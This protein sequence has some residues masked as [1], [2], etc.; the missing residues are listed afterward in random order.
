MRPNSEPTLQFPAWYARETP[1]LW[2]W[3]KGRALYWEESINFMDWNVW[4]PLDESEPE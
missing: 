1:D 4:F 2:E 3:V